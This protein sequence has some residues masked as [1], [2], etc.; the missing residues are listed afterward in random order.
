[1]AAGEL[2]EKSALGRG[3]QCTWIEAQ[4]RWDEGKMYLATEKVALG[5]ANS[6]SGDPSIKA[7]MQQLRHNFRMNV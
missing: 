3:E 2:L 6:V 5:S 1:M 7:I 4:N